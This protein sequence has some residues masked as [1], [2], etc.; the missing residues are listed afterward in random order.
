MNAHA[1]YSRFQVGAAVRGVSGRIH[2]G[3][4]VE[5]S[6]YPTGLCA[7]RAA[8]AAAITAGET[9]LVAVAVVTDMEHPAA[10]C[11]MCRQALAEFG[12]SMD[13]HLGGADPN[14]PVRSESLSDL[15]PQFFDGG[16]FKTGK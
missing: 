13:V 5:N 8:I 9:E 14:A 4:N 10:P 3:V 12:S 6:S 15:L 7:E 16:Q 11:G 2:L 1:P